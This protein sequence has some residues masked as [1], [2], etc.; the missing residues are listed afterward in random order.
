MS[1]TGDESGDRGERVRVTEFWRAVEIFSPQPLPAAN[2]RENVTI[3]S[4]RQAQR[5][6]ALLNSLG[7]NA[8][9]IQIVV[10]RVEKRLFKQMPINT[11]AKVYNDII[12]SGKVTEYTVPTLKADYPPGMLGA[13]RRK[14]D[15]LS[16]SISSSDPLINEMLRVA[17]ISW[18]MRSDAGI[19]R[20]LEH[21]DVG[22]RRAVRPNGPFPDS[23]TP[24]G[25]SLYRM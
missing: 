8:D 12:K 14:S 13:M 6:L 9:A 25:I 5:Q 24:H 7:V 17:D 19:D 16:R 23:A 18:R 20:H 21:A 22:A 1:A 2:V 11:A 4:L 3:A 10:N 15:S